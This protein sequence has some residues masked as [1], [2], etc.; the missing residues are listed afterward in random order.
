MIEEIS[1]KMGMDSGSAKTAI[2]SALPMI[3]WGLSKNADSNEGAEAINKAVEKHASDDNGL[4]WM[5][6]KLAGNP[7]SGEG[8]GILGHILW[9][10]QENVANAVAKK[11]GID[12]NQA[13]GLLKILAPMVMWKLWEA[14]AGG[15]NIGSL[16]QGET[17]NKNI[18][19]SFLDQDGDWEIT[20]DLLSMWGNF[21]KNKF[22]G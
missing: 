12:S 1:K 17:E 20:D 22:F 18:L 10:S 15:L 8:A 2:M 21:L 13:S 19:T 11:A 16:L 14:K 6:G 7:D 3:M 5:I 9:N 4:M